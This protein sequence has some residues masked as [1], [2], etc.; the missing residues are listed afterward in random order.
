MPREQPN[1]QL[2]RVTYDVTGRDGGRLKSESGD[3][4]SLLLQCPFF[5]IA[6]IIPPMSV[7][8][9]FL[10]S[11]AADQSVSGGNCRWE[12]F[13]LD[14]VEYRDLVNALT[15]QG[16]KKVIT[17]RWVRTHRDWLTW[18]REI[19]WGVPVAKARRMAKRIA[20]LEQKIQASDASEEVVNLLKKLMALRCEE[21]RYFSENRSRKPKIPLLRVR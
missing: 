16:F 5:F 1:Q 6:R 20:A 15:R 9:H 2:R 10:T 21:A 19:V 14:D 8:N 7:V 11:A 4:L 18:C 3:I 17:P 12:P 13:Q